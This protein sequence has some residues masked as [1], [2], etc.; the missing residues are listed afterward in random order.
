MHVL[1][2]A[3]ERYEQLTKHASDQV[4]SKGLVLHIGLKH[5]VDACAALSSSHKLDGVLWLC[6][7]DSSQ[8]NFLDLSDA[9]LLTKGISPL[10]ASLLGLS[11]LLLA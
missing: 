4:N 10:A 7:H 6:L 2:Q 5:V 3:A 11:L 8:D 9:D 1:H